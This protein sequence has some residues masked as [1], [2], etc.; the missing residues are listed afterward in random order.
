[1]VRLPRSFNTNSVLCLLVATLVLYVAHYQ[2]SLQSSVD[3]HHRDL[4]GKIDILQT[5]VD[6][7]NPGLHVMDNSRHMGATPNQNVYLRN[8]HSTPTVWVMAKS[9]RFSPSCSCAVMVRICTVDLHLYTISF[10]ATACRTKM[11]VI[12]FVDAVW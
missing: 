11:I 9:V 10:P 7:N 12:V 8:D 4:A 1:M 5:T 3:G 6:N 2:H